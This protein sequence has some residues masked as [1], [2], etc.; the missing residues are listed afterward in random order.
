[1]AKAA[2][3]ISVGKITMAITYAVRRMVDALDSELSRQREIN[4]Q[5]LSMIEKL[6][7]YVYARMGEIPIEAT[8][9]REV[10][11]LIGTEVDE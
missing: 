9:I 10:S 4:K 3:E 6:N 8:D 5:L 11:N 7:D 1:M 2:D